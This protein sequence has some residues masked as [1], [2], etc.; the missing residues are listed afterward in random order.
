MGLSPEH[1]QKIAA[2]LSKE[3]PEL[4]ARIRELR[5]KLPLRAIC[6]ELHIGYATLCRLIDRHN[7]QLSG[8]F[9]LEDV[10]EV[11]APPVEVVVHHLFE[12]LGSNHHGVSASLVDG[13]VDPNVYETR[14]HNHDDSIIMRHVDGKHF[15]DIAKNNQVKRVS[16]LDQ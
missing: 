13:T 15:I 2:S 11:M 9:C 1:K 6:R 4:L 3:T 12:K 5:D 10:H 14:H 16:L 7:I 8:E